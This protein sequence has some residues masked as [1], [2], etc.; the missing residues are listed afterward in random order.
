MGDGSVEGFTDKGCVREGTAVHHC[1]F[2]VG[3]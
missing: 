2:V 3:R 1:L